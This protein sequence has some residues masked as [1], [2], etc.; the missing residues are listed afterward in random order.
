MDAAWAD[1]FRLA[2]S[3]KLLRLDLSSS[4]KD[5]IKEGHISAIAQNSR[6]EE[7]RCRGTLGKDRQVIA[8]VRR[9]AFHDML[10]T[11]LQSSKLKWIDIGA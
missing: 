4:V 3:L 9:R 5:W 1:T 8:R 10:K 6:I 2:S 11:C 7:I